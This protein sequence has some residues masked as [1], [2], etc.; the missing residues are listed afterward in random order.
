MKTLKNEQNGF[1]L[2]ELVI[3]VSLVGILAV[4]A[5]PKLT[6]V[7]DDAR[8]ASLEGVASAISSASTRNY[9]KRSANNGHGTA[10]TLCSHAV[11]LLEGGTVPD[12]FA[13]GSDA[14]AVVAADTKVDCVLKTVTT[15]ALTTTF[16]A[17]GVA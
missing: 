2:V 13:L 8:Q 6:G 16:T 3:A 12:G 11:T 9:A 5:L 7:S 17:F 14:S 1:T 10:V 4:V 15:P